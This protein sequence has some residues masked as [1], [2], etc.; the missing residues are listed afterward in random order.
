MWSLLIPILKKSKHLNLKNNDHFEWFFK[1]SLQWIM[2]FSLFGPFPQQGLQSHLLC[3]KILMLSTIQVSGIMGLVGE[4]VHIWH[5]FGIRGAYNWKE[6]HTMVN[7]SHTLFIYFIQIL[8]SFE[9]CNLMFTR[10]LV[11]TCLLYT[12]KKSVVLNITDLYCYLWA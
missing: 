11:P 7:I 6:D 10:D 12:K 5:F 9:Y 4:W 1:Y 3:T 8:P 2:Q